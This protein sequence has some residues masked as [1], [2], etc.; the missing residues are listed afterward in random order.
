MVGIKNNRR[1]I[2][3]LDSIKSAFLTLLKDKEL[4][5]ITV[6][7]I[8]RTANINRGTFYHHFSDTQAVFNQIENELLEEVFPILLGQ[9]SDDLFDWLQNILEVIKKNEAIARIILAEYPSCRLLKTLFHEARKIGRFDFQSIFPDASSKELDYYFIYFYN[10][11]V[12]VI[13]EWLEQD[14]QESV[15][16]ITHILYQIIHRIN[17]IPKEGLS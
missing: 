4:S 16:E 13:S 2:Y 12:A 11:S 3:T 6:T 10:G 17:S 8:C 1:T 15:E 14:T 9:N 7:E 5:K